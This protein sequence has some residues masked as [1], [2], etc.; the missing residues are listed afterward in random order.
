MLI[1]LVVLN[2]INLLCNLLFN[3]ELLNM[4]GADI[5]IKKLEV[6]ETYSQVLAASGMCLLVWGICFRRHQAK[7]RVLWIWLAASTALVIPTSWWIQGAVPDLIAD[8]F[9]EHLRAS[10]L[11]AYVAKKG[12]LYD[13]L[14]IPRVP[15]KDMKEQGEGKAF[16]ANLGVL[17]SVQGSYVQLIDK[18]FQGFSTAVF[19]SYTARNGDALYERIQETV[20]PP[21]N[22]MIRAYVNLEGFRAAGIPGYDWKPIPWPGGGGDLGYQPS[23]DEYARSLKPGLRS[24]EDIAD[25]IEARYMARSTL[26]PVYVKGMPL[27][28]TREQFQR[29]LP[30]IA[31][32]MAFEVAHTDPHGPDAVRVLKNLWFIPFS[33]VSGLF[34]GSIS[35][36]ILIMSGIEAMIGRSRKTKYVRL[37]A[38]ASIVIVPLM[39]SNPILDSSGY[40]EAFQS[41]DRKSV[42][43]ATVFRWA[44]SSQAMLYNITKP[45][46]KA[47]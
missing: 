16:V 41:V 45:L 32:N 31:E 37:A 25:S 28:T 17:M 11:F 9:P 10:S 44:M 43:V 24:R 19:R 46:L 20:V 42:L 47:E 40:K 35:L 6:L 12:L 34:Y 14:T 7:G 33:L 1:A 36:V 22:D 4:A 26:G 8:R 23:I 38:I 29:Y 27:L 2:A 18:N 5:P 30:H 15:Y 3:A 13:S 21:V 39:V